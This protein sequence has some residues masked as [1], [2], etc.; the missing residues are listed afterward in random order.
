[1]TGLVLSGA[2]M[3]RCLQ[4][5][6][7][8]RVGRSVTWTGPV[9]T[10]WTA[11]EVGPLV[12]AAPS[13][14]ARWMCRSSPIVGDVPGVT[15]VIPTHR[16]VP[17]GIRALRRQTWPTQTL[18]VSNGGGPQTVAGADVWRTPWRGH[19]G[20]RRAA[21]ERVP[22]P[23]VLLMTDDVIPRGIGFVAAMVGHLTDGVDAVVA[24][25]VPWPT[26]DRRTRARIR[27]WTPPSPGEMPHADHVATLYRTDDLRRWA[28]QDVP[29]AEDMAWTMH[30]RVVRAPDAVVLHSHRPRM[31]ALMRRR[32]A[33][34]AVRAQLKAP[35][36]VAGFRAGLRA[37]PGVLYHQDPRDVVWSAA[38]LLGMAWG[39][40]EG[41]RVG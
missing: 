10:G 33:E 40:H 21:L 7:A 15:V 25:Q 2:D 38:E 3:T 16:H 28:E 31:G 36:P 39:A 8:L 29:I 20:T 14:I 24:R 9:P 22:T 23:Y 32:R 34:H 30:R 4:W 12:D 17:W 5:D 37:L 35:V 18:V 41:R 27:A 13:E 19:S 26:A 6:A 11:A 1:M